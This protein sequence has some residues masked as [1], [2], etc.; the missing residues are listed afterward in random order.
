MHIY[1]P[2]LIFRELY[3]AWI[4]TFRKDDYE[5]EWGLFL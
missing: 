2:F 4:G 3:K 5:D 1:R